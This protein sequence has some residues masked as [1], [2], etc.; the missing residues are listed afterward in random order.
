WILC[1]AL[2]RQGGR[3]ALIAPESWLSRDYATVV[4][5]LLFRW[6][7]I[8]FVVEDEHASWF[9]KAQVKTTLIIARRVRRRPAPLSFS[10]GES[11]S[12]ISISG[13]AA[14]LES[15]IGKLP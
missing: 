15:P 4:H 6:F 8:E 9:D 13:S 11:Y 12:H 14:T 1:A 5:Y 3:L 10:K 7:E 2:V